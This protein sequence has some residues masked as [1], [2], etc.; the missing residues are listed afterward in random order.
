[1]IVPEKFPEGFVPD[2]L[3]NKL[4]MSNINKKKDK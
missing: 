4:I 3:Q 2:W 1:M